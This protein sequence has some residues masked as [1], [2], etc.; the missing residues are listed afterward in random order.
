MK[1]RCRTNAY[2][3]FGFLLALLV[4]TACGPGKRKGDPKI[5]VFS[6]TAGFR[7]SSI[8][9]GAKA[10]VKMGQEKGFTVDTT[11][12]SAV[13]NDDSLKKYSAVVFLNTTGDV[14]NAAQ[15]AAFERYIR[16]EEHT[17]EL[18]SRENLVC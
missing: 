12:N 6:K 1:S 2:R 5:L 17:S 8:E 3:I 16:S 4:I 9:T 18:Q 14:L 15:E 13:F 7:H 10:I 11:E